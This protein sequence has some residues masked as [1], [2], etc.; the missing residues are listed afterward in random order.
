MSNLDDRRSSRR[1]RARGMHPGWACFMA[2]HWG[3]FA[4]GLG[5]VGA[6]RW[7]H[8]LQSGWFPVIA[9]TVWMVLFI[10]GGRKAE[11]LLERP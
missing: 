9:F 7:A 10:I 11:K 5:F 3:G 1:R 4:L 2:A 8:D 6:V